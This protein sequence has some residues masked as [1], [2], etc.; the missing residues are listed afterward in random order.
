MLSPRILFGLAA[1]LGLAQATARTVELR[2]K[3]DAKNLITFDGKPEANVI[4]IPIEE[5]GDLKEHQTFRFKL[6]EIRGTRKETEV[7]PPA[8][9][10]LP[11]TKSWGE[12]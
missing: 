5:N 9:C 4:S 8:H 1:I 3:G 11:R 7:S 12:S 2:Y 6:K 10:V